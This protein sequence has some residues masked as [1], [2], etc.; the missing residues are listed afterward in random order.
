MFLDNT[1]IQMKAWMR[2]S[3]TESSG[4]HKQHLRSHNHELSFVAI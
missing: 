1:V 3:V 4:A 2:V